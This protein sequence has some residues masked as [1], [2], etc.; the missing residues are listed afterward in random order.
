MA[1][2]IFLQLAHIQSFLERPGQEAGIKWNKPDKAPCEGNHLWPPLAQKT[3]SGTQAFPKQPWSWLFV[4][5]TDG[6]ILCPKD[7][8]ILI[9][10]HLTHPAC[11]GRAHRSLHNSVGTQ[12]S[13]QRCRGLGS[14]DN[15]RQ[16]QAPV[17]RADAGPKSGNIRPTLPGQV[18]P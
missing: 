9:Q 11:S 18:V 13:P 7:S 2:C 1:V 4:G 16:L 12:S 3:G 15:G 10:Q 6:A 5:T 14:P 8:D 17:Q